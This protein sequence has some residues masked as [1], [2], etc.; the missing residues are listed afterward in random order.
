M[1]VLYVDHAMIK[2]NGGI[3]LY[4]IILLALIWVLL[5]LLFSPKSASKELLGAEDTYPPN[6]PYVVATGRNL[7]DRELILDMIRK[8]GFNPKVADTVIQCE[9]NYNT[10]AIGDHGE[11]LGLWQ[12]HT[13]AHDITRECAFDAVCS[14]KY[15][16]KILKSSGWRAWTCWRMFYS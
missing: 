9:S 7:S 2:L 15:A 13:P 8:A 5:V 1:A 16:I 3:K 12:I 6:W 4:T 14:T 11:S 10:Q